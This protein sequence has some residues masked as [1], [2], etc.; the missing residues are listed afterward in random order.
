MLLLEFVFVAQR[1][2]VLLR[3]LPLVQ[4]EQRLLEYRFDA[5]LEVVLLLRLL[6][7][8]LPQLLSARSRQFCGKYLNQQLRGRRRRLLL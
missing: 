7:Y 5:L 4:V 1:F 6:E 3:L 2:L 8:L